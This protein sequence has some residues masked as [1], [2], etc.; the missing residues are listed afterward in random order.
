[1]R[2]TNDVSKGSRNPEADDLPIFFYFS[3]L[4]P[5]IQ[6]VLTFEELEEEQMESITQDSKI[7][8]EM[9]NQ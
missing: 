8:E 4:P 7:N 5:F 2:Y 3:F 9:A 1:M 6:V